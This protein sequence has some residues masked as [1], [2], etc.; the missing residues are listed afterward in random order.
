MR[1]LTF[2]PLIASAGRARFVPFCDLPAAAQRE[3][4]RLF[5][6]AGRR[7]G[8]QHIECW[9]FPLLPSGKLSRNRFIEPAPL[10]L[11]A[12]YEKERTA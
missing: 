6:P 4:R 8:F 2:T 5:N 3:A 7:A 12:T 9:A 10:A 1:Y 11:A